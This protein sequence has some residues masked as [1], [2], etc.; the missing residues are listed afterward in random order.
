MS[1]MPAAVVDADVAV[2]GSGIGGLAA[3]AL[4]VKDGA[5][6][7]VSE[8]R[9]KVGGRMGTVE[10]Q[11]FLLPSGAI[12]LP[13]GDT[14]SAL[15]GELDLPYDVEPILHRSVYLLG[16]R[17]E[18]SYT[19]PTKGALR[20][21]LTEAADAETAGRVVLALRGA[22]TGEQPAPDTTMYRWL[23]SLTDAP[24]VLGSFAAMAG[25]FLGVN[26]YEVS[27]EAYVAYVRYTA[28]GG[29]IGYARRGAGR[30]TQ[31]LADYITGHGSQVWL[32]SATE[33]IRTDDDGLTGVDVA[34]NG[35]V[36]HVRARAVISDVGPSRTLE[37]LPEAARSEAFVREVTERMSPSP[38]VCHFIV[39]DEPLVDGPAPVLPSRGGRVCLICSPTTLV[40]DL[41]PDGRH[42][43]EAICTVE[44]STDHSVAATRAAGAAGLADLDRL[45][46]DWRRRGELLTSLTYRGDWPI[47]RAWPGTDVTGDPGVPGLRCVGDGV[48]PSGVPGTAGAVASARCAVAE[49]TEVG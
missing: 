26:A 48:K 16:E 20:G 46:P 41:A 40:P 23:E 35:Q 34:R 43:L 9:G 6:V 30:L 32:R 5:S 25:A 13:T 27:A 24:D 3:A 21:L 33:R 28:G 29:S 8:R 1:E 18:R 2:I 42:Y 12:L 44:E 38:G 22:L 19:M 36:I 15:F 37:L 10:R 45:L 11:G 4:L 17:G 7:V 31:A 47:Y 39:S 14:L 49:L